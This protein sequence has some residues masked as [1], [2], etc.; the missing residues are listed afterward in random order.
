MPQTL[1]IHRVDL[2]RPAI[3]S[4]GPKNDDRPGFSSILSS[5]ICMLSSTWLQALALFCF[6]F[7]GCSGE[8]AEPD[9]W[10]EVVDLRH[11]VLTASPSL[12]GMANPPKGF[13]GTGAFR[14][15]DLSAYAAT[16]DEDEV[17]V[18]Q[19]L[20]REEDDGSGWASIP[21]SIDGLS[22]DQIRWVVSK[23]KRF[24]E[25]VNTV[26]YKVRGLCQAGNGHVLFFGRY[27]T[28]E[29]IIESWRFQEP[30][31]PDKPSKTGTLGLDSESF[32]Y[33]IGTLPSF[34]GP[35]GAETKVTVKRS[36]VLQRDLGGALQ[37]MCSTAHGEILFLSVL[38]PET[39]VTS[40]LRLDPGKDWAVTVLK[41]SEESSI[42][43]NGV[44]ISVQH[45]DET[46]AFTLTVHTEQNEFTSQE[47]ADGMLQVLCFED[48][49]GDGILEREWLMKDDS[50][51]HE[52]QN[53]L[54]KKLQEQR[55]GKR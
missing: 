45:V 13:W 43:R 15:K 47:V 26:N 21:P 2:G 22:A 42:L 29:T 11:S 4:S 30:F 3:V 55:K 10:E 32:T 28:G 16:H 34:G 17:R 37:E 24:F 19:Q 5:P 51:R 52:Y 1:P 46:K 31:V 23:S 12:P 20:P 25:F 33:E 27:K 36:R 41:T 9:A 54:F 40:L 49:N 35:E 18:I 44:R 14:N 39:K 7:A 8:E 6:L 38:N 50:E 53:M 48:L